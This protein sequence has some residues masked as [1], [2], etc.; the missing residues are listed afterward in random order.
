MTRAFPSVVVSL[1]LGSAAAGVWPATEAASAPS[2]SR[3]TAVAACERAA[4]GTLRETRGAGTMANFSS[5]PALVPGAADASELTL[6]GNGQVRTASG[7]RS[8]SYS[9]TYDPRNDAVAGVVVRD[10]AP[11]ERPATARAVEPDLSQIS[12]TAC[13]SAAAGA[14]KRRWPGVA[15]ISFNADTRQLSQ[16]AGGN[17]SL[18]GQ[19]NAEPSAR[20]PATHFSYDCTVDP[21]NGRV[22]AV[23]IA[24]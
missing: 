14:L 6:R 9:C 11:P 1:A 17:A 13:E 22:V 24:S 4:L 2:A 10:L 20:E 23:R 16:E 12:P 21:R 18:R 19:G 15:R 5:A 7:S 8:F 3:A